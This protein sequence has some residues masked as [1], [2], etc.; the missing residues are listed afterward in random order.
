MNLEKVKKE[1][2]KT[3]KAPTPISEYSQA[4]RIGKFIFVSGQVG[5]DPKTGRIVE[6]GLEKEIEQL[7]ENIKNIL[8][9]AGTSMDNIVKT[10]ILFKDENVYDVY[11]KVRRKVF[12]EKY[13]ASTGAVV[14]LLGG[15]GSNIEMD[16]IAI[17]S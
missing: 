16:V 5:Q 13:P 15:L 14:G 11:K 8:E 2:I 1:V 6:G 9:C 3:D 4:I 10:T 12:K 17:M 7:F